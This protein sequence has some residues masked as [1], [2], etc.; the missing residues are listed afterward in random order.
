MAVRPR[1][2][3][4]SAWSRRLATGILVHDPPAEEGERTVQIGFGRARYPR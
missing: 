2:S 1:S 3:P 4:M